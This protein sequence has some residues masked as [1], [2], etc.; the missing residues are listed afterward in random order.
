MCLLECLVLCSQ[1]KSPMTQQSYQ[2]IFNQQSLP[3]YLL[4]SFCSNWDFCALPCLLHDIDSHQ[5]PTSLSSAVA[6]LN[7]FQSSWQ[8][9]LLECTSHTPDDTLL[10]YD[11][12]A[13][14]GFTLFKSD[15]F[16]HAECNIPVCDLSKVNEVIGIEPLLTSLL[17]TRDNLSTY[18]KFL[19][20]YH[21]LRFVSSVLKSFI[22]NLEERS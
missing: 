19:I 17:T 12:G 10:V 18:H 8:L 1:F 13:S 4:D 7:L 15:F 21:Y 14:A 3:S 2:S 22:R 9:H 16:D 6:H 11:L 20:I 5:S